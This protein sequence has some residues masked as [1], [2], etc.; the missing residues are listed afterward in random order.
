MCEV[1]SVI[2]RVRRKSILALERAGSRD[3]KHLQCVGWSHTKKDF[4]IPNSNGEKREMPAAYRPA[5]LSFYWGE[6]SPFLLVLRIS[7]TF[8]SMPY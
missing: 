8:V 7:R 3:A 6:L 2:V 5:L 4:P 1:F